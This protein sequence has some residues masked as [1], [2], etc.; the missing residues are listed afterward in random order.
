MSLSAFANAVQRRWRLSLGLLLAPAALW[1]CFDVLRLDLPLSAWLHGGAPAAP[2]PLQHTFFAIALNEYLVP[3]LAWG[4]AVA[5]LALLVLALRSGHVT[6]RRIAVF[7]MMSLALGPGLVVNGIL[8]PH[9]GRP[10]PAEVRDFGGTRPFQ[11]PL[12][13]N[14]VGFADRGTN[15]RSFPSGHAAMAFWTTAG[16]F[17]ARVLWP[18]LAPWLLGGGLLFGLAGGAA[19]VI[20]GRHFLSDILW[21]GLIVFALNALLAWWLLHRRQQRQGDAPAGAEGKALDAVQLPDRHA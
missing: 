11:A 10:R 9:W 8:K 17:V 5:A 1:L 16:F 14:L 7:L 6:G 12:E 19:R 2:F 15:G 20:A 21:S 3:G 4:S 18:P 13:A